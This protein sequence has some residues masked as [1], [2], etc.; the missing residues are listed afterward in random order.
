[1][2]KYVTVFTLHPRV[3]MVALYHNRATYYPSLVRFVLSFRHGKSDKAMILKG[4]VGYQR[5]VVYDV[6]A[7][8][9]SPG[10]RALPHDGYP[11]VPRFPISALLSS[12]THKLRPN[13]SV[14]LCRKYMLYSQKVR[15]KIEHIFVDL[16]IQIIASNS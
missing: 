5:A 16:L 8:A 13:R 11:N 14:T 10:L 6:V 3:E 15:H 1:M 12:A 4:V 9:T 2:S 7:G